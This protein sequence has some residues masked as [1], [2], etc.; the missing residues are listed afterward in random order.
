MADIGDEF[1]YLYLSLLDG[2]GLFWLGELFD[3]GGEDVDLILLLFLAVLFKE[4]LFF[5]LDADYLHSSLHDFDRAGRTVDP[6]LFDCTV[7]GLLGTGG[8]SVL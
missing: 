1:C 5:E 6:A 3:F 8:T 7:G 4:F 2:D